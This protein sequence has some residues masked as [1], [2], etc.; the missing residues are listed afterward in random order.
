MRP[1][2]KK[3]RHGSGKLMTL[4]ESRV[5]VAFKKPRDVPAL[6]RALGR[7][8]FAMESLPMERRA[9][10]DQFLDTVNHTDRAFWIRREAAAT[11]SSRRIESLQK[12]FRTSLDYIAP[13]YQLAGTKGEGGLVSPSPAVLLVRPKEGLG[14]R[15][16]ATLERRLAA[17]GLAEVPERSRYLAGFR[18]FRVVDLAKSDAYELR[19]TVM[20]RLRAYVEDVRLENVPFLKPIALVPNDALYGDQWN[21]PQVDAEA[22]WEISAGHASVVVAVLDSGCD[23]THPDLG[24]ASDGVNLATM[25]DDGSPVGS[26]KVRGHGTCCGGIVAG[27]IDNSEGVAGLAGKCL[28]LPIAFTL[29]SDVECAA[30]ITYAADN[31]AHVLSM[32][33]GSYGPDEDLSP[34]NWDFSIIDPAIEYA[35]AKG[36]VLCAATGNENVNTYNRYPARHE[37]VMA[38]GGSSTDDDRKTT[39]SPDGEN[40]WGANYADGVSVVAPCVLIPTADIQDS[41]GYNTVGGTAGDYFMTF[42]GTSSATPHLAAL[43]ALCLSVNC[44][45][46]NVGVQDVIERNAAKVG[47]TPYVTTAGYPNGTR[48]QPMG[49]GRIDADDTVSEAALLFVQQLN[50]WFN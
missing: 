25:A 33:F 23:L 28:I 6:G 2:P 7:A 5:F 39:T 47:S 21:M 32:S 42:N 49:Y 36:M 9:A 40:W 27:V 29:W 12:R 1:F 14:S 38:C 13:V 17:L 10:G 45:I 50:Q 11:I 19:D 16:T 22:T 44:L 8:G 24:F 20:K 31:G 15:Q 26:S 35:H 48:N 46:T 3:L 41:D 37:L 18:C 34:A 4:D 43:A 30:G